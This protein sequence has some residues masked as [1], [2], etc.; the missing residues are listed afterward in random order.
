MCLSS[1]A[2]LSQFQIPRHLAVT[3]PFTHS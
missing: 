1:F 3:S 2:K